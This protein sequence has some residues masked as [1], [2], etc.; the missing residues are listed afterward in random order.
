MM[1]RR[2]PAN[3]DRLDQST[4]WMRSVFA[5][6]LKTPPGQN[7]WYCSLNAFITGAIVEAV[8]G[9]RRSQDILLHILA[10]SSD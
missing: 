6:P 7:Y 3:E 2:R 10:A 1:T 5:V 4:D 9:Q 8:I